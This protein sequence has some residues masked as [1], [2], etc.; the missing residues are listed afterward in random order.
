M[1]P[2]RGQCACGEVAYQL[3]RPPLYVHACHCT[4]CQRETGTAFALN[5]MI[6]TSQLTVLR[7]HAQFAKLPTDSGNRHWAACCPRCHTL[8]WNAHGSR[9]PVI[10][11]L[12]VGTLEAPQAWPPQAHIFVRSKLPWMVLEPAIPAF[13]GYYDAAGTWP[14]DSLA[15]YAEAKA[16]GRATARP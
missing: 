4:C 13:A 3:E 9:S 14:A 16:A 7:G 2:I 6:E 5:A 8:L 12:R 1:K 11:Y 10:V 15:R